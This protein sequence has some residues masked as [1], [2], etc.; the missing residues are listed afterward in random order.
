MN[1]PRSLRYDLIDRAQN[2][3]DEENDS[4]VAIYHHC[5]FDQDLNIPFSEGIVL[6][7]GVENPL[8]DITI[9]SSLLCLLHAVRGQGIGVKRSRAKS[10]L[11]KFVS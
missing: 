6:L 9:V 7:P 10:I 2:S 4:I 5:G 11:R 1:N 8:L 3:L